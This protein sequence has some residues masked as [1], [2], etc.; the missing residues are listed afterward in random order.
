MP[1]ARAELAR[2]NAPPNSGCALM[3]VPTAVPPCASCSRRGSTAFSRSMPFSICVRQP[4]S[5][6]PSVTGI[7]SIRCVRPV[8]TI[9]PTSRL[10]RGAARRRR[11]FERRQQ[12]LAQQQRRA[13]TWIARRDHVVAALAHV[14]VIVRHARACRSAL[15]GERARSP[16]WRSCWCWCRS[17]SGTRRSGTA[18]R[19]RRRRPR[20]APATIAS[21][22]S[23]VE[24][25]ERGVG[26]RRGRLDQRQRAR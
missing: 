5:S 24:Q 6:W 2:R 9:E 8:L 10:L 14:D 7:A 11:C 16:R 25:P 4:E 18:R 12:L 23:A 15:R 21:A 20:R 26:A 13:L 22:M 17:R 19:A 1:V 3:P